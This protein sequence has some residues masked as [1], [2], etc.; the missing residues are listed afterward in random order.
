VVW[1]Q[2]AAELEVDTA[3]VRIRCEE[4][5]VTLGV[6][7]SCDQ[8]DAPTLIE[9]PLAVGTAEAP[10]GLVMS[11]VNRLQG[12][13][14]VTGAWSDAITAFAWE[15]LLEVARR[16]CEALGQDSA[17][18]AIV[19]GGIAAARGALLIQPMARPDRG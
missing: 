15:A 4:G 14:V 16:I 1:Q 17:R 12:P 2:G 13:Q 9:V 5:L 11:T 10:T 3:S 7:V 6:I 19:P 18:R 8:L